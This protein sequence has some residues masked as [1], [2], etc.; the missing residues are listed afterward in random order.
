M[1]VYAFLAIL[2]ESLVS[3]TDKQSST[4]IKI[5]YYITSNFLSVFYIH[6]AIDI[7][8]QKARIW[9]GRI[10]VGGDRALHWNSPNTNLH[11][12]SCCIL[13]R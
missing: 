1:T 2:L 11:A 6:P 12:T 4:T 8:W 5:L 7:R 10:F 3:D 9:P 13:F